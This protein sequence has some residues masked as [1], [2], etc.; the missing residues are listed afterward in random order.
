MI[1]S[2]KF[3]KS[4]VLVSKFAIRVIFLF[5]GI[6]ISIIL[7]GFSLLIGA[8]WMEFAFRMRNMG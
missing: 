7:A 2:Y 5:L 3:S 6:V 1:V 8:L 4:R